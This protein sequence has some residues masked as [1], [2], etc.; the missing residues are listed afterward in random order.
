M[1]KHVKNLKARR[2]RYGGPLYTI[3][4]GQLF[5]L[6]I[7]AQGEKFRGLG[8]FV[9]SSRSPK[10]EPLGATTSYPPGHL[11]TRHSL[12]RFAP[13]AHY[14]QGPQITWTASQ[15]SSASKTSAATTQ[16]LM[17]TTVRSCNFVN[18]TAS[19]KGGLCNDPTTIS[20]RTKANVLAAIYAGVGKPSTPCVMVSLVASRMERP[21]WVFCLRWKG[22]SF[23]V[24]FMPI[25]AG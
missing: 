5:C 23:C 11:G 16:A 21:K 18:N 20:C 1:G 8:G 24:R 19:K 12:S 6:A 9:E 4:T 3:L 22:D 2:K 25:P 10:T 13:C 17:Q 14:T 15:R 7:Q